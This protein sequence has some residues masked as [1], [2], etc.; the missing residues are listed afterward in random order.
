MVTLILCRYNSVN[1]SCG[2]S[3]S[4]LKWPRYRPPPQFPLLGNIVTSYLLSSYWNNKSNTSSPAWALRLK[5]VFISNMHILYSAF[6]LYDDKLYKQEFG[7][8][9]SHS[10]I[11][12]YTHRSAESSVQRMAPKLYAMKPIK[13][14]EKFS[15]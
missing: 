11:E 9:A 2:S 14:W 12:N 5:D 3:A 10:I 4:L 7:I 6:I 15:N 13:I 1:Q 8:W